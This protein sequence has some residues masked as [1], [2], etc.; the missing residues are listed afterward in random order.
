MA[1]FGS[2]FGYFLLWST[3]K[4]SFALSGQEGIGQG[5][6]EL[7]A[8][9]GTFTGGVGCW[10]A[11]TIG[12]LLGTVITII[13]MGITQKRIIKVPFG[14]YLAFGGMFFIL[15]QPQLIAYLATSI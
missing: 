7:L 9:I 6:L 11:L 5:D 15:F 10:F 2:I 13:I 1:I 4:I 3:K 14:A 8:M 12:S